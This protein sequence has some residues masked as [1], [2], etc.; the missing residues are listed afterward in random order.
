MTRERWR[1]RPLALIGLSGCGKST[2]APLLADILATE[3]FDVDAA[4]AAVSGLTAAEY[5]A[6]HGEPAF[7]R[8]E[9]QQLAVGLEQRRIVACGGG[10]VLSADNRDL[11]RRTATVVWLDA[12]DAVILSR[13]H[14]TGEIRPNLQ[15]DAAGR[16]AVQRVLRTPLYAATADLRIDS[17][18]ADPADLAARIIAFLDQPRLT[19]TRHG[20]N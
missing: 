2:V 18:T 9:S 19:E 17:G 15:G 3:V 5:F 14:G 12:D 4:I 1:E 20:S 16:L 13:L 6:R 10:I 7:R 8:A 11:L